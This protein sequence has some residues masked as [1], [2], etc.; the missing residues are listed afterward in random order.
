MSFRSYIKVGKRAE[1]EGRYSKRINPSDGSG[2]GGSGG[3]G[4]IDLSDYVTTDEFAADQARQ[5]AEV[6]ADQE[7][8]DDEIK[9]LIED[10]VSGAIRSG[11]YAGS[12]PATHPDYDG[13]E[14]ALVEGDIS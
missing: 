12:P 8:Q 11:I 1:Y 14:A 3:S 6:A 4:D 13:A 9:K 2:G 7:R 10:E 5:D